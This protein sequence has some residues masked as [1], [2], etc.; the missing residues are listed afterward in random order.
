MWRRFEFSKIQVVEAL[1]GEIPE[2][3][4]SEVAF[5]Q[6]EAMNFEQFSLCMRSVFGVRFQISGQCLK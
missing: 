4:R 2:S 3:M 6:V 1:C 5:P